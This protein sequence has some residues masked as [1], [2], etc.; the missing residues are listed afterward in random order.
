M[1]H[2]FVVLPVPTLNPP[3]WKLVPMLK[4]KDKTAKPTSTDVQIKEPEPMGTAAP[5]LTPRIWSSVS[6]LQ[7]SR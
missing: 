5:N 4:P 1:N 6:Y 2:Y 3:T 7:A